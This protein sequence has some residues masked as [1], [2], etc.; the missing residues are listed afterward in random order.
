MGI[1]AS[2]KSIEQDFA[3]MTQRL[4][5]VAA[6]QAEGLSAKARVLA[7]GLRKIVPEAGFEL[8]AKDA[9]AW[10]HAH[11]ALRLL[12]GTI[13]ILEG[14]NGSPDAVF[15][16]RAASASPDSP[17]GEAMSDVPAD[18]LGILRPADD[19]TLQLLATLD[20]AEQLRLTGWLR[21]FTRA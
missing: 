5:A 16:S 7:T 1:F 10:I 17:A 20:P 12:E 13:S 3:R 2:R 4:D 11:E 18:H 9:T 21:T 8:A 6:F 15:I 19:G 14:W